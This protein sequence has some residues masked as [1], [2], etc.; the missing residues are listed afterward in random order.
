MSIIPSSTQLIPHITVPLFNTN[1]HPQTSISNLTYI[2]QCHNLVLLADCVFA[3]NTN[4]GDINSVE[5]RKGHL[6]DLV[7]FSVQHQLAVCLRNV[8][9]D[10][11]EMYQVGNC[12]SGPLEISVHLS[13][14]LQGMSKIVCKRGQ[15]ILSFGAFMRQEEMLACHSNLLQGSWQPNTADRK[16]C[17]DGSICKRSLTCKHSL[18]TS[19]LHKTDFS[20]LLL[21]RHS[22]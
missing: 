10:V 21:S 20:S 3:L 6:N 11:F 2:T 9:F 17:S 12:Q 16:C 4:L 22:G 13:L 19:F 15:P 18:I 8:A 5:R 14:P 7:S 1:M